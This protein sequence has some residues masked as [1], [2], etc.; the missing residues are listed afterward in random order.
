MATIRSV[1]P[2]ALIRI[3]V[4]TGRVSSREAER[5][6]FATV[7]LN[8]LASSTL[9]PWPSPAAGSDGK[10]SLRRTRR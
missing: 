6:T 7:S 10:S 2:L 9:A 8:A 3:P 1:L 5:A 4:S